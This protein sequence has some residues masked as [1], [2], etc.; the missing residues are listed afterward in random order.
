MNENFI[1]TSIPNSELGLIPS[2]QAPI[3]E[4]RQREAKPF[5]I[6]HPLARKIISSWKHGP[7]AC[8]VIAPDLELKGHLTV[9]EFFTHSSNGRRTEAENY[10]L[11]LIETLEGKY[12]GLR[13]GNAF[14]YLLDA[15]ED[16][17][18]P[19]N[20][21]ETFLTD[22]NVVLNTKHP[23]LEVLDVLHAGK[24][25]LIKIDATAFE[26]G[27]TLTIDLRVG[28]AEL[29]GA[30]YLYSDDI[31]FPA[32]PPIRYYHSLANATEIKPNETAQI[33]YPFYQDKVFQ[34][35]VIGILEDGKNA[36]NAFQARFSVHGTPQ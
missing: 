14:T 17:P 29:S 19:E 33:V 20:P 11:F 18:K 9:N 13:Q 30:F 31:E 36:T 1:N 3:A 23:A 24:S 2:L 6:T 10:R 21:F 25:T 12:P 5:D 32:E 28:S 22:L 34:L 8:F 15:V 27:G 4:T 7:V 35:G 26:N 16:T